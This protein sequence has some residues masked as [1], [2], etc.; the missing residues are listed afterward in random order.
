M[1]I[2]AQK[3]L[4]ELLNTNISL[5]TEYKLHH[6]LQDDPRITP[7]GKI[8]RKYSLDELP[9]LFNVLIG[10]M[11]L[12][13]PRPVRRDELEEKYGKHAQFY[14]ATPPGIT[15]LWQISGRN[16][17]DYETRVSLDTWY[18]RNWTLWGDIQIFMR[19]IG[20]CLLYTS[21]SPRD[22]G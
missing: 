21:P 10:E 6:K 8:I 3:S 18:V 19:T 4:Q 14:L 5:R 7:I 20:T 12:I 16:N 9:Q 11:S 2:N 17:L 13:G 1:S 15:G 22:R